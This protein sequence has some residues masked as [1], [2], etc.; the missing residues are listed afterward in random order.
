LPQPIYN[1]TCDLYIGGTGDIDRSFKGSMDEFRIWDRVLS[2]EEIQNVK[3]CE[4]TGSEPHL[5]MCCH[6]NQGIASGVNDNEKTLFDAT[7]S[8]VNV[9]SSLNNFYL[10]G[11]TS[12][13]TNESAF[14]NS[15]GCVLVN[16][17]ITGVN[18][19]AALDFDG[20]NDGIV[21]NNYGSFQ[22]SQ[23]SVEAWIK[24]AD[25]GSGMRGIV[26]K[27]NAYGVYLN[28]NQLV[29]FDFVSHTVVS[30]TSGIT[31]NDNQWHHIAFSFNNNVVNGSNLY[32]DGNLLRTF[33]YG[34]G[35]QISALTI[36]M[37]TESTGS[38]TYL[39]FKGQMDEV[40]VWNR[41]I[42][43]NEVL[44]HMNCE[45]IGNESNLVACYHFN[46]GY[47]NI[48]N[49]SENILR[50]DVAYAENGTLYNFA[51]NGASSNWIYPG[52]VTNSCGTS[53]RMA[54]GNDGSGKN[55]AALSV[56]KFKS[57]E[58]MRIYPNP[59]EGTINI[60]MPADNIETA[61][62]RVTD[63]LGREVFYKKTGEVMRLNAINLKEEGF[64][65]VMVTKGGE[66]LTMKIVVI[67]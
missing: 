40:H 7:G 3:N 10:A 61:N 24:T 47:T 5:V 44:A 41:V 46:Q 32:L 21:N 12:N 31:I 29:C 16:N 56:S 35:N 55:P 48:D 20:M 51:L 4:M 19:G 66:T 13:W 67:Q 49:H 60:E 17:N 54:N 11:N 28:N 22:L 43:Q 14:A 58:E 52:A 62:I 1:H 39:N 9:R 30:A 18:Y 33:T 8:Y 65:L 6:L 23:G 15:P 38:T 34:V 37:G 36:G 26:V 53:A 2:Q 50:D 64:Y 27:D 59:T 63:M 42:S 57:G 45:L 25:A